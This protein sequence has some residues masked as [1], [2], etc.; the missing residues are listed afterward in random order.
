MTQ[1]KTQQENLILTVSEVDLNKNKEPITALQVAEKNQSLIMAQKALQL[2]GI[3]LNKGLGFVVKSF[4]ESIV[5]P[6]SA[7]LTN[8]EIEIEALKKWQQAL[9]IN[10]ELVDQNKTLKDKIKDQKYQ[11]AGL[12][13]LF[14]VSFGDN[15]YQHLSPKVQLRNVSLPTKIQIKEICES[16]A[17]SL[18]AGN[19]TIECPEHKAE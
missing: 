16:G 12:L 10:E 15:I 9:E 18:V 6:D 11:M 8:E 3:G 4:R 5:N 19:L 13:L 17:K 14:T 1:N 7:K 2:A